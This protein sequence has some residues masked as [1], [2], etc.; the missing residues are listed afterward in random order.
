MEQ[1]PVSPTI[2]FFRALRNATGDAYDRLGL[3]LASSLLWCVS[4][5]GA[6]ALMNAAIRTK[7]VSLALLALFVAAVIVAEAWTAC[8]YLAYRITTR[9]EPSLICFAEAW[10]RL[11]LKTALLAIVQTFITGVVLANIAVYLQSPLLILRVMGVVVLYILLLWATAMLYQYPLLIEHV[12]GAYV[13]EET[14]VGWFRRVLRRSL[15]LTLGNLPFSAGMFAI[16]A[17]WSLFCFFSVIGLALMY[18]GFASLAV[19]QWTRAL[20]IQY[21]VIVLPPQPEI[22]PDE[23]FRLPDE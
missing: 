18:A 4:L 17:A 22:V 1:Q 12:Y 16:I 6:L 23:R 21:G 11:G 7:N 13:G 10:R 2:T 14:K 20:L 8:T 15:L 9:D 5:L 19:V 3:T